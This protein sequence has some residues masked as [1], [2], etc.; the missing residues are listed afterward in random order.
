MKAGARCQGFGLLGGQP[1]WL[2]GE[3]EGPRRDLGKK[4]ETPTDPRVYSLHGC[5]TP[6]IMRVPCAH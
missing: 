5:C 2:A 4:E 3:E 1:G 6:P